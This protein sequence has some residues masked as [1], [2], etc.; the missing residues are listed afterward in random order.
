MRVCVC[1]CVV[2]YLY[3]R[4]Y[5]LTLLLSLLSLKAPLFYCLFCLSRPH[6]STVST[7]S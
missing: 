3:A 2:V 4:S 1:L 5:G 6:S 7:V